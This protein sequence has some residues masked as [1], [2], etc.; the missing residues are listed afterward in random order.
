M[1]TIN[2]L[3]FH[4]RLEECHPWMRVIIV[5]LY[6]ECEFAEAHLIFVVPL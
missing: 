4:R 2:Q 5:E 6:E 1:L 3:I